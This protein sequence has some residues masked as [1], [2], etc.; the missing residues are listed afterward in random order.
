MWD[1]VDWDT[2]LP[3]FRAVRFERIEPAKNMRRFYMLAWQQ[4]LFGE[5]VVVRRYG[6][7]GQA[8][9]QISITPFASLEAAWPLIRTLVKTR[10]RHGYRIM[11]IDTFPNTR[12][13]L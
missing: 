8:G 10:L 12:E 2:P 5:W 9:R 13:M 7:K 4:T 6:R 11:H 1:Q 3:G